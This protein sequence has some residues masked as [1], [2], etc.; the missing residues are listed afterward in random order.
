MP[1]VIEGVSFKRRYAV[2]VRY[3]SFAGYSL[4]K[5][6]DFSAFQVDVDF[7]VGVAHDSPVYE[8]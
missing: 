6:Q 1:V 4:W 7:L 2:R 3:P 8:L 5:S